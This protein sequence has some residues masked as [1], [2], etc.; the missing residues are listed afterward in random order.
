MSAP[1]KTAVATSP[2]MCRH[3]EKSAT[4]LLVWSDRYIAT[5][6]REGEFCAEHFADMIS[7][8]HPDHWDWS[9]L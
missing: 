5:D 6:V 9:N 2:S 1:A 8:M 4:K 3:C 7:V